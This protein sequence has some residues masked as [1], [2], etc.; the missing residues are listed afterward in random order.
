MNFPLTL[1]YILKQETTLPWWTPPYLSPQSPESLHNPQVFSPVFHPPDPLL[2][3]TQDSAYSV[4]LWRILVTGRNALNPG[5]FPPEPEV[6]DIFLK[7][8]Q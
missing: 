8:T 1:Q 7:T 6:L 3:A 2:V 5:I 4:F